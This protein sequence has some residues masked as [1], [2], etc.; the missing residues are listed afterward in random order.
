MEKR[1]EAVVLVKPFVNVPGTCNIIPV[2][3]SRSKKFLS[4]GT[5]HTCD[6]GL[7]K[8]AATVL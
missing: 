7:L 6:G 8:L 3:Q 5:E 2:V 1:D 4:E